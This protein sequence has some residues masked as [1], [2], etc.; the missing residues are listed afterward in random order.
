MAVLFKI[1]FLPSFSIKPI[2]DWV[3]PILAD[4]SGCSSL[5][6]AVWRRSSRPFGKKAALGLEKEDFQLLLLLALDAVF[7]KT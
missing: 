3:N 6:S 7:E 2:L 4:V 1:F 5:S